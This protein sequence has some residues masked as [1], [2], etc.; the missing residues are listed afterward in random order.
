M[1][2]SHFK[3]QCPRSFQGRELTDTTSKSREL[4]DALWQTAL[5]ETAE[6][7]MQASCATLL[8]AWITIGIR[9]MERQGRL[10]TADLGLA[11]TNLRKFID[12]LKREAVFLG[13]P[14]RVDVSIFDSARRRL[15]RQASVS[16]FTL[17]PF[18]PLNF[19]LT[20]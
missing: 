19:V 16:T 8:R 14:N 10:T 1:T 18:W 6:V 4:E 9:R 17:W 15:R 20:S 3:K 12:L 13:K 5:E 7:E 11:H 2:G